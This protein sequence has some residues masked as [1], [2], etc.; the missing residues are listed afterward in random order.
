[1]AATLYKVKPAFQ[2]RLEPVVS[3]LER[4][5][6]TPDFVTWFGLGVSVVAGVCVLAAETQPSLLLAIPVLLLARMGANAVDGQ[7]ARRIGAT[8]R[9]ALLNE[10]CDVAGDAAAY[11]PFG[12]LLADLSASLAV[13][14]VATGL[15][16]EVAA[17]AGSSHQRRN[18]GPLGKADRALGFS[19]L[20]VA[21]YLDAAPAVVVGGLVLM[22]GLGLRTVANRMHI[23]EVE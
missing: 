18:A 9:G 23:G 19:V 8:K 14:V 5:S 4:H 13:A 21:I 6:V 2:R 16:S 1:M 22:L 10:V 11:L 17:I 20:A 15:I 3:A 7:L 12:L